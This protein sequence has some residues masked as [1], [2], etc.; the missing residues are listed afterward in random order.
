MTT[1]ADIKLREADYKE[2]KN[3]RAFWDSDESVQAQSYYFATLCGYSPALHLPYKAYLEKLD[4]AKSGA[5]MYSGVGTASDDV[6]S[7][8]KV[9]C[10]NDKDNVDLSWLDSI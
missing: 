6:S 7:T 3:D 9:I 10:N 2:T 8:D 5:N 1:I 4:A